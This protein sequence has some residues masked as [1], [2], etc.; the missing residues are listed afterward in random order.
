MGP[1]FKWKRDPCSSS[2]GITKEG[3]T[4]S[5]ISVSSIFGYP[6]HQFGL[7]VY[8]RPVTMFQARPSAVAVQLPCVDVAREQQ[9]EYRLESG[10]QFG[11]VDPYN[12]LYA[13]VEVALHHVRATD[14]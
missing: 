9:A 2:D 5:L 7:D 10:L 14:V 12:D 13:T 8:Q 6:L 11:C 3:W 1:S 4:E